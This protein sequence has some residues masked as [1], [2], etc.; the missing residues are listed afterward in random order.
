MALKKR[1]MT[2]KSVKRNLHF[3]SCCLQR[4]FY[5]NSYF[6][7]IYSLNI[8]NFRFPMLHHTKAPRFPARAPRKLLY[9]TIQDTKKVQR[10]TS[11]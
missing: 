3:I 8:R 10:W 6:S 2:K 11:R 7:R 4:N 1:N 5:S 9:K